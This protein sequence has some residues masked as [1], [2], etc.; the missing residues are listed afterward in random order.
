MTYSSFLEL[1]RLLEDD[2][3]RDEAQASRRGG[4]IIP[5]L[6]LYATIRYLSGA[7]YSDICIFCGISVAS[8]YTILWRTIHV[9]NNVI[10]VSFP[11]SPDDCALAA[12]N[13]ENISYCGCF[14]NCV[15]AVDGFLLAIVTPSKRLA[16]NVR[17][18]FSGHYQRYGINI[19]A[20]CDAH[21][22]F[23]FL[24]V[25]GPGVTNDR[26]GVVASGLLEKINSLPQGYVII[27]DA[28]YQP[29]EKLVPVFGG[30]LALIRDNSNFNFY[31]SQLRIRI[32]MAFGLM[33]QKWG[34]LQRPLSTLLPSMSLR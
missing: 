2:L 18:Y 23:S 31:A 30:S 28:A 33:T 32:E 17:S 10:A 8:F 20:S 3:I 22:R 25:G 29:S 15:A 19:Q 4:L 12:A 21:C 16:K 34:I 27:G 6:H 14:K 26:T 11:T 24:G 13:F 9:L 7:S 5:E 1:L